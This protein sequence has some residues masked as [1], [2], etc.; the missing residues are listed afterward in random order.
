MVNHIRLRL[1]NTGKRISGHSADD[2]IL[3]THEEDDPRAP[4]NRGGLD[5]GQLRTV[6]AANRLCPG[7]SSRVRRHPNFDN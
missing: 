3:S 4:G 1:L 5:D 7:S 6:F 2:A